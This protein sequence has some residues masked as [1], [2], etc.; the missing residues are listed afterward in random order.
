LRFNK[1]MQ[2]IRN[3]ALAHS[4]LLEYYK[5]KKGFSPNYFCLKFFN[6]A[7]CKSLPA[8]RLEYKKPGTLFEFE[9]TQIEG[10]ESY[11]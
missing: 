1:L 3:T 2:L 4:I 8:P 10:L 7:I 5:R 9:R 6:Y 11:P